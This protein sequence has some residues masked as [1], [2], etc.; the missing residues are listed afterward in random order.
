MSNIVHRIRFRLDHRWTPAH[1]S[2]YLDG[3][4]APRPHR[5]I[6][7]HVAECGQCRRTLAALRATLTALRDLP[8][9]KAE[10]QAAQITAA[11]RLRLSSN[12]GPG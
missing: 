10:A 12:A 8:P 6:E 11:V 7:D 9:A 3:D 4:L 1:M 2:D 5:R